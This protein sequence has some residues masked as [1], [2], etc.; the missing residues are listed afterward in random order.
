MIGLLALRR[1]GRGTACGVG[2][3]GVVV[4]SSLSLI[5]ESLSLLHSSWQHQHPS[6]CG[7]QSL[8]AVPT[9][10]VLVT[11]MVFVR[12]ILLRSRDPF[13]DRSS[14]TFRPMAGTT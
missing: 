6:C 4:S 9:A 13:S 3:A 10:F 7:M 11:P 12:C 2:G 14:A 1:V 8:L 5:V